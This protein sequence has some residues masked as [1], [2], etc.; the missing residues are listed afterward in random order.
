M[1]HGD[2]A[3]DGFILNSPFLAW[4]WVGGFI[5]KLIIKKLPTLLKLIGVRFTPTH[6]FISSSSVVHHY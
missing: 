4:G 5:P 6:A 2:A 3:F 1:T